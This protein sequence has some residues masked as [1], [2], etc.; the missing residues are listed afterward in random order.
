M[1]LKDKIALVTGGGRG[2]GLFISKELARQ[3]AHVFIGGTNLDT[4]ENAA[5]SIRQNGGNA[6]AIRLDVTRPD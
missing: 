1:E 3:G 2:I 4:A 6:T 5:E